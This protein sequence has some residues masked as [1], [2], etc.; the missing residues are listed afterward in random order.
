MRWAAVKASSGGLSE[1]AN[2]DFYTLF[3]R[4]FRLR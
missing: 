1:A 2:A 3:Q 4:S